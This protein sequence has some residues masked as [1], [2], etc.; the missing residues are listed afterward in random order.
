MNINLRVTKV[1]NVSNLFIQFGLNFLT[2][3][4]YWHRTIS[5]GLGYNVIYVTFE[6]GKNAPK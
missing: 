6:Y 4:D 1:S 5:S 2:V 3:V